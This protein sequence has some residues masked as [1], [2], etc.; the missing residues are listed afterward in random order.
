M[1]L[2]GIAN[3][4]TVRKARAW[5]GEHG[6]RHEWVDFKKTPPT[7]AQLRGWSRSV[8][9]ETL[10]NRRGT[11]WRTLDTDAQRAIRDE[12][13]AIAAM[14]RQPSLIRRPVVEVDGEVIVGFEPDDYARR[15]G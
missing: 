2:Y 15:F 8:G 6:V 11:T 13:S 4:D 12:R 10:V 14:V 3:C 1:K 7:E 9:W 5:L